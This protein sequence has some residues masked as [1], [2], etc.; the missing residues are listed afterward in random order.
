M[1]RLA[2]SKQVVAGSSPAGVANLSTHLL[3]K[4]EPS[5]SGSEQVT[6]ASG[7][8]PDCPDRTPHSFEKPAFSVRLFSLAPAVR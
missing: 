1:G 5:L 2:V 4:D 8:E 3:E 7:S 6:V